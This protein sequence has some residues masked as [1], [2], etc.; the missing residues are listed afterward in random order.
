[1]RKSAFISKSAAI[2]AARTNP[3]PLTVARPRV[4]QAGSVPGWRRCAPYPGYGSCHC[5]LKIS[6]LYPWLLKLP[7]LVASKSLRRSRKAGAV[8]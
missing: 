1:M 6:I 5:E 3:P 2:W 4:A 7:V 8:R